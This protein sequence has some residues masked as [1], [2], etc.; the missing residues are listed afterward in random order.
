ME[1]VSGQEGDAPP[2]S[3]LGGGKRGRGGSRINT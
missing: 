1:V 2:I 3:T